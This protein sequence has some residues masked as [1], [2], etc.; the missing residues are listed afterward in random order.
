MAWQRLILEAKQDLI[1]TRL[2]DNCIK[3]RSQLKALLPGV[4]INISTRESQS[5]VE[6]LT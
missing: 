1:M 4:S 2:Q 6:S 5:A 3:L